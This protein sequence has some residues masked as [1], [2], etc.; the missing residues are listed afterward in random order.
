MFF[1][2]LVGMFSFLHA[3]V[4]E[5]FERSHSTFLSIMYLTNMADPEIFREIDNLLKIL[6]F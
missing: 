1:A 3:S 5:S 4:N 2:I 6:I